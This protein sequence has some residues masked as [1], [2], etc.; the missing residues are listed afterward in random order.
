[1]YTHIVICIKTCV[2]IYIY[3]YTYTYIVIVRRKLE[4]SRG[5]P[6]M[7]GSATAAGAEN[8]AAGKQ[9]CSAPNLR[10]DILSISLLS[11]HPDLS[12][13]TSL[14]P[15]SSS[16]F[17]SCSR[18]PPFLRFVAQALNSLPR[19]ISV[20]LAKPC[21]AWGTCVGHPR[22]RDLCASPR[23]SPGLRSFNVGIV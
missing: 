20:N 4:K 7:V 10:L 22:H 3:T 12:L 19:P 17:S 13:S 2:Y 21:K 5:Q 14:S 18:G 6:M 11:P 8:G 9:R 1:M 16:S 15:L 23:R